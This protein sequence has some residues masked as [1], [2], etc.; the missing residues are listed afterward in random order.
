MSRCWALSGIV[1]IS[2]G[3]GE[4]VMRTRGATRARV[5]PRGGTLLALAFNG[6]RF[7]AISL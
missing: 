2:A 6:E 3:K 5:P 1:G 4:R 7:L